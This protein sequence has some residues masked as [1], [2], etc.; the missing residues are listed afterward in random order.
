MMSKKVVLIIVLSVATVAGA[1]Y[2]YFASKRNKLFSHVPKES[3]FVG[4][5]SIS[6]LFTKMD[7]EKLKKQD[8]VSDAVDRFNEQ[9]PDFAVELMKNP[10]N[11]GI[12]FL[13]DPVVFLEA[14]GSGNDFPNNFKAGFLFGVKKRE[15]IRELIENISEASGIDYKIRED[16]DLGCERAYPE[17][18][19]FRNHAI[20]WNNDVAVILINYGRDDSQN[21]S[22]KAQDILFLAKEE[23]IKSV[24]DFNDFIGHTEDIDFFLNPETLVNNFM[25]KSELKA[26]GSRSNEM[27]ELLNNTHGVSVHLAF[28]KRAVIVDSYFYFDK[29]YK[30]QPFFGPALESAFM[31]RISP[32]GKALGVLG[33]SLD[34]NALQNSFKNLMGPEGWDVKIPELG[35][36]SLNDF[37]NTFTGQMIISLTGFRKTEVNEMENDDETNTAI[38]VTTD[39]VL[40]V[41]NMQMALTKSSKIQDVLKSM[42]E[43]NQNI[44]RLNGIYTMKIPGLMDVYMAADEEMLIVTTDPTSKKSIRDDSWT[45]CKDDEVEETVVGSLVSFY[46]SLNKSDYPV[47][48]LPVKFSD[49]VLNFLGMFTSITVRTMHD[50]SRVKLSLSEGEGNSLFRLLNGLMKI[51]NSE[52]NAVSGKSREEEEAAQNRILDSLDNVNM[53]FLDSVAATESMVDDQVSPEYD[54]PYAEQVE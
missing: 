27:A 20:A 30:G 26:L 7:Y 18:E 8:R 10:E 1:T 48:N 35:N 32:D 38:P 21:L 16:K 6:N 44:S 39:K 43:H 40:P 19:E 14:K 23:C 47:E 33:F 25:S 13:V 36:L 4:K 54:N 46:L 50:N 15:R 49:D 5:V 12:D 24:D 31:K 37:F 41:L 52:W 11:S 28:K 17:K 45:K 22:G 34:L 29:S 53:A 2:W 51:S 9:L 42:E 3:V